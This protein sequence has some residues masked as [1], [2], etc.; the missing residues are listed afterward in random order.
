VKLK[1]TACWSTLLLALLH[2]G[3]AKLAVL[4]D[5]PAYVLP[6]LRSPPTQVGIFDADV[7]GP[8][9]PLMVKPEK[10]ILEMNP[11]TKV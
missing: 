1:G 6:F 9:L 3:V 8:S 7:Y 11:D 5:G 10:P 2:Q 4:C